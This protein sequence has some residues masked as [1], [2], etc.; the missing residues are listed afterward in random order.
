MLKL[1]PRCEQC[2]E[3][4][5][6]DLYVIH[7]HIWCPKCFN[8]YIVPQIH[9]TLEDYIVAATTRIDPDVFYLSEEVSDVN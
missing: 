6:E 2:G 8:D 9:M 5:T 3:V 4:L 7:R 1:R